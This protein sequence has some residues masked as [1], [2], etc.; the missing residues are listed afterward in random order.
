MSV[1]PENA[2]ADVI[3]PQSWNGYAYVGNNPILYTDI[4]GKDYLI[5]DTSGKC[6]ERVTDEA[7]KKS[8][9]AG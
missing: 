7:F 1:D 9:K 5:C 8:Q 2:G 4:N 6:Y 3:E